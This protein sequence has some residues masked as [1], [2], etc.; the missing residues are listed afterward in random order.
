MATNSA[1]Q[2]VNQLKK[3]VSASLNSVMDQFYKELKANTPVKTGHARA[4]WKRYR[5]V[6]IGRNETQTVFANTVP[7]IG[8]LDEGYSKQAPNGIVD[9]A[10]EQA[11]KKG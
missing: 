6:N 5:N 3:E 2:C 1:S 7:Y 8:R 4:G 10:W 9:P 11:N